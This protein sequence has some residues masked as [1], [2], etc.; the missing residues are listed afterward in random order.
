MT[1]S[2][3]KLP[4][5]VPDRQPK[6]AEDHVLESLGVA[7]EEDTAARSGRVGDAGEGSS[8]DARA[9][10]EAGLGSRARAWFLRLARPLVGRRWSLKVQIGAGLGVAVGFSV[11]ASVAALITFFQVGTLQRQINTE[12]VPALTNAVQ[13][14][15]LAANLAGSAPRVV[16]A[17]RNRRLTEEAG[18]EVEGLSQTSEVDLLENAAA[19][20]NSR[21]GSMRPS[22]PRGF[23]SSPP[24]SPATC[25]RSR[26][27]LTRL[28]SWP[29]G[30]TRCKRGPSSS[31]CN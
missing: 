1:D 30:W 28:P 3:R 21:P 27:R 29:T 24:C 2:S 14:G 22:G 5:P 9:A 17:A 31:S 8:G 7:L 12:H 10:G 16:A 11:A 18:A 25:G 23:R 13:I 4:D 6:E 15:Q 20:S 26:S 19:S